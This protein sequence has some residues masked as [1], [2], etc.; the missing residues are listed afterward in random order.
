MSPIHSLG[1]MRRN[2]R[3]FLSLL[4]VLFLLSG[5]T[6]LALEVG[7]LQLEQRLSQ[8]F[9]IPVHIQ[10]LSIS[11]HR[12]TLQRI[13]LAGLDFPVGI[14]RLQIQGPILPMGAGKDFRRMQSVT[15]TGLTLS[16]AGIPLQAQGRLFLVGGPGPLSRC[17]GWLTFQHP[18]LKGHVEISGLLAEPVILG[19]VE[20]S[21]FERTHFA[22]QLKFTENAIRLTRMELP[23][24]WTVSGSLRRDRATLWIRPQDQIPQELTVSWNKTSKSQIDLN[25]AFLQDLISLSGHIDLKP[26]Y[27]LDLV[28]SLKGVPIGEIVPWILPLQRAPHLVGQVS[29][30][31]ALKGLLKKCLSRGELFSSEGRFNREVFNGITLRFEGVG[32]I[33]QIQ[34]SQLSKPEGIL[35]MEGSV[36]LRR[37]G[38]SDF[39]SKVQLLP[40]EKSL[41]WRGWRMRSLASG[42][43]GTS[44]L[45]IQR[46]IDQVGMEVGLAYEVD[47]QVQTESIRRENVQLNYPLSSEQRVNLRL[48]KEEEFVGVEHR[49]QF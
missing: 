17:D 31:V 23:E 24:G 11:P 19:W 47:S 4:G 13:S 21:R 32:P 28:L 15:L 44:G 34:N 5:G 3:F 14:E 30:R 8:S 48:N 2:K 35:L 22:G 6:P 46:R 25:A 36:D 9:Q 7:R 38:Q 37:L 39:F 18:L 43:P 12:L 45:E 10:H 29:G 40:M 41:Q 42:K 1:E 27:P 26:P 33:L 20:G 49:K 16:F